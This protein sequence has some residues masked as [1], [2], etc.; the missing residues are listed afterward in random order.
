VAAPLQRTRTRRPSPVAVDT[1]RLRSVRGGHQPSGHRPTARTPTAVPEAADSHSIRRVRFH[2]YLDTDRG[3]RLR[4]THSRRCGTTGAPRT[5][6]LL[7]CP[8]HAGQVDAAVRYRLSGHVD[9]GGGLPDTGS[10]HAPA[11]RTPTTAAGHADTTAAVTLD[12]RQRNL[13][14]PQPCPTGTD[15][16]VQHRAARLADRQIRSLVLCVDLVGSRRIWAAHVGCVVDPGGS[17]RV[18]SDRLGDQT[19]DQAIQAARPPD[20]RRPRLGR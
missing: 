9:T 8:G 16:K 2:N 18:L 11:P 13:P 6:R 14:A 4:R 10:P 17:R 5:L 20:R 1:R 3:V 19:D 15:R 7:V 12:S